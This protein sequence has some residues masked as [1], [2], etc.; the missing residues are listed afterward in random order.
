MVQ[1]LCNIRL[2]DG[3]HIFVSVQAPLVWCAAAFSLVEASRKAGVV[4]RAI[5]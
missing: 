4:L 3:T 1:K 5:C 2:A